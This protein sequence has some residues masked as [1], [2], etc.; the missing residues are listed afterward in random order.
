MESR[1]TIVEHLILG[2]Y[3]EMYPLSLT[4]FL[5][6][7]PLGIVDCN[8]STF[9]AFHF[10]HNHA[11]SLGLDFNQLGSHCVVFGSIRDQKVWYIYGLFASQG[12]AV[13]D[14]DTFASP[15]QDTVITIA[16]SH[17]AEFPS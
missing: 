13:R 4:P 9:S 2:Y 17:K 15:L 14:L 1:P 12:M 6:C 10:F 3:P 7:C 16:K 5:C 11:L 8:Y